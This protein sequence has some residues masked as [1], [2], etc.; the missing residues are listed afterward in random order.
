MQRDLGRAPKAGRPPGALRRAPAHRNRLGGGVGLAHV[1]LEC[2]H[3]LLRHG[4]AGIPLRQPPGLQRRRQMR[5]HSAQGAAEAGHS[6]KQACH[7]PTL[8]LHHRH[9]QAHKGGRAGV[10]AG[11]RGQQVRSAVGAGVAAQQGAQG[12]PPALRQISHEGRAACIRQLVAHGRAELGEH[13]AGGCT[14]RARQ[15]DG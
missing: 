9:G 11:Q 14:G 4:A 12:L 3:N 10:V 5:D 8:V 7:V 6:S 2:L 15:G 13:V 1:A